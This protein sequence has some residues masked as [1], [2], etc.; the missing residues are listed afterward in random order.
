MNQKR[1]ETLT[2]MEKI[3]SKW[4]KGEIA[5]DR[6]LDDIYDEMSSLEKWE[7]EER[8]LSL[9]KELYKNAVTLKGTV[10]YGGDLSLPPLDLEE[11]DDE[12]D[13]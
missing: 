7:D 9:Q 4:K 2:N 10:K 1:K 6:A 12:H 3:L 13:R 8:S 5:E 11:E